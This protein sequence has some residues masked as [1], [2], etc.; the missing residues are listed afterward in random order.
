MKKMTGLLLLC[1][2][3][4]AG[5]GE[6]AITQEEY[7]AVVAERD[8]LQSERDE[9]LS[10]RDEL[11]SEIENLNK[12]I[13][14]SEKVTEYQA[15]IEE[16]H[17]HAKFILYVTGKIAGM[18]TEELLL[19]MDDVYQT[20]VDSIGG[21]KTLYENVNAMEGIDPDVNDAIQMVDNMWD[22]WCDLYEKILVMEKYVMG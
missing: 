20:A 2:L 8:G 18:D 1:C 19:Q 9:L 15:R 17:E 3:V 7:D 11:E 22:A 14:L 16:Q 4:F 10:E 5:C 6:P 21:V 12:A 13:E